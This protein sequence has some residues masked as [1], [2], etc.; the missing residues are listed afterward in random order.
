[1]RHVLGHQ[2]RVQLGVD[3]LLDVEVDLLP[4]PHLELVLQLLDL[5]ALAADDD[6][7]PRGRDRDARA[8]RGALDVDLRDPRV[9]QLI[10]D[11]APDLD[12]LVQEVRVRLRREPARAP[13]PR[14]ADP[15]ADRMCF[16]AHRYFFSFGF[17]LL[18]DA[19]LSPLR[20]EARRAV[21]RRAGAG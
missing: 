9:V 14:D 17:R 2:L 21:V 18:R 13:A 20:A 3:D 1:E 10:L 11:E 15:E 6:A 5:G 19:G 8:I 16:L 4:G 7:G 12:V